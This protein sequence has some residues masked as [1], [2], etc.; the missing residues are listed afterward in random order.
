ML[1]SQGSFLRANV[2]ADR[3][4]GRLSREISKKRN[5]RALGRLGPC[6]GHRGQNPEAHVKEEGAELPT[7][8]GTRTCLPLAPS[9]GPLRPPVNTPS[10]TEVSAFLTVR[11]RT[12][13]GID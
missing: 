13:R 3:R 4:P 12:A 1:I 11:R 7:L 5:S 9:R 2:K 10:L 6:D 8:V